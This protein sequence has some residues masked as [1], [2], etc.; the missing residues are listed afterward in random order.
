ML[1][2]KLL[3]TETQRVKNALARRKENIDI[4]GVL[5]IDEERR[6]LLYEAEQMKARQNEVSKKIPLLKKEG[7]DTSEVFAEMKA[8]SEKIKEYDNKLREVEE[9]LYNK[10][11][12]IPNIP[13]ET[14]P[15]GDTDED[16]VEIRRYGEPTKFDF[17][18]L[19]HWDLGEK[20]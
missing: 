1:D 4:D 17:E 7:K 20:L 6:G 11:L 2:I 18:A 16:N 15:A 13:N 12:T 14:V 19:P 5:A 10:M 8:L 9:E 3:R